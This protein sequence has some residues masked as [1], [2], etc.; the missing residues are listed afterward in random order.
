MPNH[1]RRARALPLARLFAVA[2]VLACS[3]SSSALAAVVTLKDITLSPA[4]T[5]VIPGQTVSYSATGVFSDGS[6][7][8]FTTRVVFA[9]RN[10]DV[11]SITAGGLA[12]G[13]ESGRTEIYATDP[14]TGKVSRIKAQITVATLSALKIEPATVNLDPG[15]TATLKAFATYD[16]GTTGIDVT[17]ALDWSSGKRTVATVVKNGDGTVVVTA[18]KFGIAPITARDPD[19]GIKSDKLTG[20]VNVG[21]AGGPKLTSITISP[22]S[23]QLVVDATAAVQATGN[24]DNGTTADLTAK[25]D[26]TSNKPDVAGVVKNLD[27][28]VTVT[29][30]A[31]GN[32]LLVA[33]DPG[34]GLKSSSATGIV[35]VIAKPKLVALEI[36]LAATATRVGSTVAVTALGRYDNGDEDVDVTAL[37]EWGVSDRRVARPVLNDDGTVNL[38][39]VA[40]G[41]VKIKARDPVAGVKTEG[42]DK[43]TVV[44]TLAK[45]A[46][47]PAKK[48]IRIDTRSRLNA[49]GTFER[50]ITVDLSREVQ[51]TSSAPAIASVDT[52]G[53]VTGV[54]AGRATVSVFDP[55]TG[56]SS[57]TTGGDSAVTIVGTLL[58][59]EVTPR[60]LVLALGEAGALRAG[61]LFEGEPASVNLSSKVDWIVSDPS[62]I[63]IN[64]AGGVSCI[65]QGS[66]FVSAVDP[67]SGVSSTTSNGDAEVLCGVP[68][69]GVSVVPA[70][71]RLKLDKT[72]KVKAFI[73]YANGTQI[74]ITKRVVW[75]TSNPLVVQV[76]NEE[77][78]IGKLT[79]QAP[80]EAT[81]SV[82][83]TVTGVGS[84]DAGG[85]SLLVTVPA[86]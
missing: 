35:Q 43:L 52:Q 85:T 83:D 49:I 9:S 28:T 2:A 18:I 14:S 23:Q 58:S 37:V 3:L 51:W 1:S 19:T 64:A 71:V 8:D 30:I 57:T 41:I 42:P 84:A 26:W 74:D 60:V 27:G 46:V 22:A 53:R 67:V 77:P 33:T 82:V 29:A 21:G 40:P 63:S 17:S 13:V 69:S 59:L 31:P 34:T 47:A 70:T 61:G 4:T 75:S 55:V 80:G 73:T 65:A 15:A 81:I 78:N 48:T 11:V 16:N 86:P 66:T 44:A 39:G 50:G 6:T 20:V 10:P 68:I 25:V 62:I 32:A 5:S 56:A 36:V 72:K 54:S 12:T 76:D 24:Y 7:Q 79:P 45:I 38:L